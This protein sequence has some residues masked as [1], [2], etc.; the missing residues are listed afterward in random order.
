MTSE[1]ILVDP[2]IGPILFLFSLFFIFMLVNSIVGPSK[3]K[4]YRQ[5]LSNMYVAGKI[6]QIAKSDGIDLNEEFLEFARVTKNKKIDMEALDSTI[7]RELQEK[8][9]EDKKAAV[10]PTP[11]E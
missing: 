5:D 3:S 4:A 6:R 2:I 8:I 11:K 7:E 10:T 1:L 9:A